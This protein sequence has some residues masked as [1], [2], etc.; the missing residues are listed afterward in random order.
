MHHIKG[1]VRQRVIS[2]EFTDTT[3]TG[4]VVQEED[5]T[6]LLPFPPSSAQ[7]DS[8]SSAHTYFHFFFFG[9]GEGSHT[10]QC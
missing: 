5:R 2:P 9:G 1:P 8:L 3:E 10:W 4:H 6:L 7:P